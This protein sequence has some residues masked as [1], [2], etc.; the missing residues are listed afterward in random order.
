MGRLQLESSTIQVNTREQLRKKLEKESEVQ[1]KTKLNEE[2]ARLKKI[3]RD[4]Q[5]QKIKSID[6]DNEELSP[7]SK[8]DSKN[9][10]QRGSRV[11]NL[12][13]MATQKKFWGS[14]VDEVGKIIRNTSNIQYEKEDISP[15]RRSQRIKLYGN[16]DQ[17][18]VEPEDLP[19]NSG[20]KSPSRQNKNTK[21]ASM[22]ERLQDKEKD[23]HHFVESSRVLAEDE[24]K[25]E[26]TDHLHGS[27]S[28]PSPFQMFSKS[29]GTSTYSMP[30]EPSNK[31]NYSR[32]VE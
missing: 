30:R 14:R 21:P 1:E 31:I 28:K 10:S 17:Q 27:D 22:I 3:I 23:Y 15:R 11:Q 20:T 7:L 6:P 9:L 8:K 12:E 26:P 32:M 4:M 5:I 13:G 18:L 25:R 16:Q 29:G 2:I 19:L 24:F